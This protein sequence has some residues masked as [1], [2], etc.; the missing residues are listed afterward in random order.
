MRSSR[1][2][3]QIFASLTPNDLTDVLSQKNLGL[4]GKLEGQGED[5]TTARLR[6]EVEE[7]SDKNLDCEAATRTIRKTEGE[8]IELE[9]RLS[10][11]S[12]QNRRAREKLLQELASARSKLAAHKRRQAELEGQLGLLQTSAAEIKAR[13]E[14]KCAVVCQLQEKVKQTLGQSEQMGLDRQH[15]G[16]QT[17][18]LS[19]TLSATSTSLNQANSRLQQTLRAVQTCKDFL[20]ASLNDKKTLEG[21]LQR[22]SSGNQ[23]IRQQTKEIE[24][25]TQQTE[26]E[27][28][29]LAENLAWVHREQQTKDV[30]ALNLK[31][32]AQ[33]VTKLLEK[34]VTSLRTAEAKVAVLMSNVG[35]TEVAIHNQEVKLACLQVGQDAKE[36]D[37]Q[38]AK[39]TSRGLIQKQTALKALGKAILVE[40]QGLVQADHSI[41]IAIDGP[42]DLI[43]G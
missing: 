38:G 18:R 6:K 27:V 16:Q 12:M 3:R 22:L 42:N 10:E 23:A 40:I 19:G 41:H 4:T 25:A 35:R 43:V 7:L 26:Q 31:N 17:Q 5:V 36:E 32:E 30:E 33:L 20:Q 21:S 37:A 29:A 13:M 15:K 1:L 2:S 8:I 9:K 24:L 11:E 34:K 28:T 14:A 39:A